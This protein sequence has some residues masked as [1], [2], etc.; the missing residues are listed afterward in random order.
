MKQIS[1]SLF[2]LL[3]TRHF[4]NGI[5]LGAC[6]AMIISCKKE[7]EQPIKISDL[8]STGKSNVLA[9]NN[10]SM[11]L[12]ETSPIADVISYFP[13]MEVDKTESIEWIVVANRVGLFSV[14]ST[15]AV[16]ISKG[17]I[18]GFTH[19][20]SMI[21]NSTIGVSWSEGIVQT[22]FTPRV[23]LSSVKGTLTYG[24]FSAPAGGLLSLN[25]RNF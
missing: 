4:K 21:A 3:P 19:N 6:A 7:I 18:T 20:G 13:L 9:P 17:N 15:E 25:A 1:K 14:K 5:L 16:T 8:N 11:A 12:S 2:S 23:A 22:S 24:L 10:K